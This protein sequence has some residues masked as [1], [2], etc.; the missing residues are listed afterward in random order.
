VSPLCPLK[1]RLCCSILQAAFARWRRLT[2]L[3][4]HP[5]DP[6]AESLRSMHER[7]QP[8]HDV[9]T[10]AKRPLIRW[11]IGSAIA[12]I[13]LHTVLILAYGSGPVLIEIPSVV[14]VSTAFI[15]LAAASVAFLAL[16]RFRVLGDPVSYWIGIMSTVYTIL[17]VLRFLTWPGLVPGDRSIIRA[18]PNTSAWFVNI[19]VEVSAFGLLAA[20]VA[21]RPS[22]QTIV[23]RYWRSSVTGWALGT[24][25]LSILLIR[26]E[27]HLP[28][29][30]DRGGTFSALLM[31]SN[32][33][34]LLI[35][36][37]SLVLSVRRYRD[38]G[39]SLI[40][41]LALAQVVWIFTIVA[42]L[43][44]RKRYD[45]WFYGIRVFGAGGYLTI[46]F[47]LLAEY[48]ALYKREREK[49]SELA[50][51]RAEAETANRAKDEFLAM[52]GHELRNPLGAIAN[53][54]A[55]LSHITHDERAT[56]MIDVVGRQT[57]Q[58]GRMVDDLLDVSRIAK[59]SLRICRKLV[60]VKKVVEEAVEAF[61][62]AAAK[63]RLRLAIDPESL[64][65]DGDAARLS[66]VLTNLL[67]NA[68]KHTLPEGHIDI[69]VGRDGHDVLLVVS[70]NGAGIEPHLLPLVFEPFTQASQTVERPSSGLGLGLALVRALTELHR[71]TVAATSDGPGCGTTIT[72]RLPAI[73]A[74]P[75]AADPP[76]PARRHHG[77]GR[78][79]V[80]IEDNDDS[81][82]ALR[83][84]LET[85]G[86][87]VSE[88]ADGEVGL[89]L[90]LDVGPE[91]AVIDIG[92][93]RLNGYEIARRVRREIGNSVA[94]IALT[95]FGQL[96]DRRRARDAGFD[97]HLTKP[98][99]PDRLL[100]ALEASVVDW[101]R[102]E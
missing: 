36:M 2:A 66:Q 31:R 24:V 1:E 75:L 67:D 4:G 10:I 59:R 21:R 34:V 20:S 64:V 15:A 57:T 80:V 89:A 88:A 50:R 81:R 23:G 37:L 87:C 96:E 72:V 74:S 63:R 56:R 102:S 77:R 17:S 8:L 55:V 98:I 73:T 39:D 30:V 92:L 47:G 82:R 90:L 46:M 70:D 40:G 52:L 99:D 91:L 38:S 78:R 86:Y 48:V 5:V 18:L 42:S 44:G 100:R 94:L 29:L 61:R 49:A 22:P 16:G 79:V 28:L 6:I 58:L 60:D 45:L 12:A 9:A 3:Y 19:M 51:A 76:K 83:E 97:L 14:A 7:E 54:A 33:I 69:T 65:V 32:A 85:E 27:Q 93:P 95:G 41:Y 35:L 43:V 62:P 11:I 84:L 68:V 26:L 101:K 25:A 71:G 53:A 13:L